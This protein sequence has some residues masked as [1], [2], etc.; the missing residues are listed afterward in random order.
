MAHGDGAIH[1]VTC[2]LPGEACLRIQEVV[3]LVDVQPLVVVAAGVVVELIVDTV[4]LV[5]HVTVLQV[6]KHVPLLRDMVGRLHKHVAVELM[7]VGVVV[8]MVAVDEILLAHDGIG[9]V[10]HVPEVV[11]VEVLKRQTADHVPRLVLIVQVPD[12]SVGVLRE[13]LLAHEVRP[14]DV[15]PVTVG[16]RESKLRELVVRTELTIV[17]APVG[18][19]QRGGCGPT[20]A[21][22]PRGGED[23]MV[24]PEVVGGLV[25]VRTVGHLVARRDIVSVGVLGEVALVVVGQVFVEGVKLTQPGVVHIF[26][27]LDTRLSAVGAVHQREVVVTG[28]HAVPGLARLL[29]VADVLIADLEVVAQPRQTAVVRARTP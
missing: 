20:V 3:L 7:S 8:G 12:Q 16:R 13:S 10:G 2:Q 5:A 28:R 26:I 14:L 25:P 23:V 18:I 9:S 4:R 27:G 6:G 15:V 11:A 19:V 29:E 21:D 22:V 17:A 24:L 1:T